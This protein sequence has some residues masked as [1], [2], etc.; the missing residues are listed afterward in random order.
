MYP[1]VLTLCSRDKHNI[2]M[3]KLKSLR[4]LSRTNSVCQ[5]ELEEKHLV[6]SVY[7]KYFGLISSVT[8]C[9]RFLGQQDQVSVDVTR[10]TQATQPSLHVGKTKHQILNCTVG[11]LAFMIVEYYLNKQEN[12]TSSIYFKLVSCRVESNSNR[13]LKSC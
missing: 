1:F 9:F 7:F 11:C 2:F 5:I 3:L 13:I 6:L 12:T 10:H 8:N 4:R